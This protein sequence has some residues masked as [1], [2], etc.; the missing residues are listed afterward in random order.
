ME[1]A[2]EA[3]QNSHELTPAVA[4]WKL[5]VDLKVKFDAM[6]KS[7]PQWDDET[8]AAVRGNIHKLRAFLD[9]IER[10]ITEGSRP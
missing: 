9:A 5:C 1:A 3:A 10:Q 4:S 8:R 6:F 2:R 7:A